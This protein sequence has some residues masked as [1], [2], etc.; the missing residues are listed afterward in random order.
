MAKANKAVGQIISVEEYRG[1]KNK[2]HKFGAEQVWL[3]N[4]RFDSKRESVRYVELRTLQLSE[5][6][7]NL[8]LQRTFEF[9]TSGCKAD[10][11]RL[12]FCYEEKQRG[13]YWQRVAEDVTGFM[14]PRKSRLIRLFEEQY[15]M[16][17]NYSEF[18]RW[19][20]RITK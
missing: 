9:F 11:W 18:E 7:R 1:E 10:R 16:E 15:G 17:N 20:L 2:K 19:E 8:Q 14:T 6:I 5:V 4:I 13:C 3:D 12:D